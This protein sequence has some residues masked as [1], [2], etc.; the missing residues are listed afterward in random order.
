MLN[1]IFNYLK[2][3]LFMLVLGA[4]SF[5]ATYFVALYYGWRDPITVS[6]PFVVYFAISFILV[7]VMM[8]FLIGE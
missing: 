7:G 4:L 5:G 8:R 2:N 1:M 6:I 3:Q